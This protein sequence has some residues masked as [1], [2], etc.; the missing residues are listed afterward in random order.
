MFGRV[1]SAPIQRFVPDFV[2]NDNIILTFSGFF[3]QQT[4]EP[5]REK[6][7]LIRNV[8]VMY[9]MEDDTMTVI[10][11]TIM[12]NVYPICVLSVGSSIYMYV[13]CLFMNAYELCELK[14]E[15][16][17][18]ARSHHTAVSNSQRHGP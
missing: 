12:V 9:F 8:K 13:D 2:K 3:R 15:Q 11:P 14:I 4:A 6:Y 5:N 1:K 10:E 17:I 7:D 16:W 18:C